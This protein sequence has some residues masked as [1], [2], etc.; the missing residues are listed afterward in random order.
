MHLSSNKYLTYFTGLGMSQ[1]IGHV[2][3]YPNGGD[4]MPGCKKNS[5]AEYPDIDGIWE[6]KMCSQSSQ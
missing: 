4:L 6:G 3:F 2:D 5:V 1:A